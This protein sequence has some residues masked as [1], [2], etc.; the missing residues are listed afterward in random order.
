ML[1]AVVHV[2]VGALPFPKLW[3]G[4][5]V[6]TKGKVFVRDRTDRKMLVSVFHNASQVLQ[7]TAD[8]FLC[9]EDARQFQVEIAQLFAKD[10]LALADLKKSRDEA[11][12][13]YRI[14]YKE[15]GNIN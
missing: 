10:R 14:E 7:V 9:I 4:T 1:A 8:D 15:R 6:V 11:Y 5:H 2:A 3:E 13:N 12:A